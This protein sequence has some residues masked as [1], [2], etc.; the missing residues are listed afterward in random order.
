MTQVTFS[1]RFTIIHAGSTF[2]C[3]TPIGV[4]IIT[5]GLL[6]RPRIDNGTS[7]W[8]RRLLHSTSSRNSAFTIA[9]PNDSTL[10]PV[11]P[12]G[13]YRPLARSSLHTAFRQIQ[14]RRHHYNSEIV[15]QCRGCR[16]WLSRETKTWTDFSS[17]YCSS[18]C[19]FCCC[20]SQISHDIEDYPRILD[21]FAGL[22]NGIMAMFCLAICV[23]ISHDMWATCDVSNCVRKTLGLEETTL[24]VA[25]SADEEPTVRQVVGTTRIGMA[26][27]PI[28]ADVPCQNK[29]TMV[30]ASVG[31]DKEVA[32]K[33]AE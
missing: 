24:D 32:E 1:V 21:L 22:F 4:R 7:L 6:T 5:A 12:Q 16:A 29:E 2:R 8:Q 30:D 31:A 27:W 19:C 18:S 33:R 28:Y 23:A 14:Q 20:S 17:K 9:V 11:P 25:I 26:T 15:K 13:T 10:I 3:D